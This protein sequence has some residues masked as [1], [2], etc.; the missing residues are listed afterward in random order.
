MACEAITVT[1]VGID[2]S[3]QS[4]SEKNARYMYIAPSNSSNKLQMKFVITEH[5]NKNERFG[6]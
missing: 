2:F 1:H 5:V 3:N 6:I 4:D